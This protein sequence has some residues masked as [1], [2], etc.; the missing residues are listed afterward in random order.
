MAI[1]SSKL[2]TFQNSAKLISGLGALNHL[3]HELG[4]LGATRPFLITDQGLVS[5]GLSRNLQQV[6]ESQRIELVGQW[7]QVPPDAPLETVNQIAK[8]YKSLGADSIIALGGGSVLDTAKGVNVLVSLGGDT[9]T[10]YEG[11]DR[12][13]GFMKPF[14][15]VPT[16]AGTGSEATQVAVISDLQRGIKSEYLSYRMQPHVALLDPGLS[17]GMPPR[18]TAATGMDALVHSIEAYSGRQQNP[19][20]K[21][22]AAGAVTLIGSQL[23]NA[24]QE[25]NNLEARSAMAQASYMAGAAFSNSMV[26]VIHA[27]G[28]GLGAV[29]HV[30]HG[31]AMTMLL[32]WGMEF[33][34]QRAKFTN[35]QNLLKDYQDLG[36]FFSGSATTPETMI[37]LILEFQQRVCDITGLPR[38]LSSWGVKR[39]ILPEVVEKAWLDGALLSNPV[40]VEIEDLQK[41]LQRAW[42]G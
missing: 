35:N 39:E 8:E 14:I 38:S 12:I 1:G 41:I 15:A 29:A 6:L 19:L 22:H 20:S 16:T 7:S 37:Q 27:L 33:N 25:P 40:D 32:P 9:L 23:L 30:P 26:G 28:H 42:D 17:K 4:L 36:Y 3:P 10:N 31:E 34:L 11:F 21:A 2:Y 5:L 18:L 24:I 13:A